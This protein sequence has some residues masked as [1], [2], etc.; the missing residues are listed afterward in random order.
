MKCPKCQTE[1]PEDS[2]FCKECAM[3][4]PSLEELAV[5]LTKTIEAPV[6]ELSTGSVFAGRY[7]IIEELGRGGMGKVYRVLDKKLNEE[8]ALK[9]IKQEI[10][11]D[12]KTLERSA[13]S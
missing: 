4:L 10:A 3:A 2:K 11:S 9:L 12:K 8:I 7:Q 13:T 1:N 6:E 5:S